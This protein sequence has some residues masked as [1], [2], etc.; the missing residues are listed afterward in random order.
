[1]QSGVYSDLQSCACL[2]PLGQAAKLPDTFVAANYV[3]EL[4][5][6]KRKTLL[7]SVFEPVRDQVL[8]CE[9]ATGDPLHASANKEDQVLT[10][11]QAVGPRMKRELAAAS[12]ACT[13]Q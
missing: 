1:M 12:G 4:F 3:S 8:R 5:L 7:L 6:Q 2:L 11:F 13:L 9:C 10:C